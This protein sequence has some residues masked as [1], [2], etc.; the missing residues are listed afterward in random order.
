MKI[1]N[2]PIAAKTDRREFATFLDAIGSLKSGQSFALKEV[3][4]HYRMSITIANRLL[5]KNIVVRKDGDK[6]RV[7]ML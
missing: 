2:K 6:F 1:E 5:K 7:G 3:P 4:S